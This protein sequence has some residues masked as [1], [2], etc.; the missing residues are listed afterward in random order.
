MKSKTLS[1]IY[2]MLRPQIKAIIIISILAIIINIGEVV[3]PYLIKVVIDNYLSAGL[4][5]K[6]IMTIGAIGVAYILIVLIGNILDFI[7]STTTSMVGEDVIYTIRNKLYRYIQYANIPFHDKTPSGTL[8]VRITSDVEDITTFFKDVITTFIKDIIMI[9]ALAGMMLTLNYKLALICFLLIPFV[10]LTSYVITK[11]SRKVQ[12]YSK[13]AKT[14]VNIFLAESIY[15]VKLIKI[16]NRQYEKEKE[17]SKL[18]NDFYKSRIPTAF[19]E[20][21][22]IAF[23]VIFENLGIA[24]IT[25]VCVNKLFNINLDVGI[26]Y[27]FITYLKQIFEPIQR[28][29]EN[30]ETIQE[31][32]VSINKIYDILEH[33]EY[34]EDFEKGT[35]LEEIKGKIEFKN[36]WF[37]YQG[38]NWILKDVNFTIEPG[39]SVA[40][41]GKTGSRKNNN[42]QLN[43]SFL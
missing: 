28:L 13:K 7:V 26:I 41:V 23:M 37:A 18:C 33:K 16:F 19:T 38:E 21:F 5:Q 30:F 32:M 34:L 20:G 15:G 9:I 14:K 43:K 12:E 6:G 27:I 31:A 10:I 24:L 25:W 29:V 22:L 1:R 2:K 36:V 35:K 42:Y 3:K 39:Q 11:M 40:I 8:F 17:C 4:W